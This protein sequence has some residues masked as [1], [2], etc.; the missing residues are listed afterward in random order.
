MIA[1]VHDEGAWYG[2]HTGYGWVRMGRMADATYIGEEVRFSTAIDSGTKSFKYMGET[3]DAT[4]TQIYVGNASNY[5]HL[6]VGGQPSDHGLAGNKASV[7]EYE[8]YITALRTNSTAANDAATASWKFSFSAWRDAYTNSGILGTVTKTIIG[9][10]GLSTAYDVTVDIS[11]GIPRVRVTGTASH[12]VR[13]HGRLDETF[14]T[15]NT[16][17]DAH[18]DLTTDKWMCAEGSTFTITLATTNVAASTNV[19]YTITGVT[20]ADIGNAS[21]TGNFVVGTTDSIT[22]TVTADGLTEGGETFRMVLDN[23]TDEISVAI[24]E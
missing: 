5:N 13:W 17:A 23:T 2:S 7:S 10:Q 15:S 19:A 22:Y 9:Q 18:Y 1:H 16:E 4:Q 8:L 12:N 6:Q 3:T 20:S 11:S 14:T 24:T 21:L